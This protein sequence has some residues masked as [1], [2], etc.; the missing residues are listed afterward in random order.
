ME[1]SRKKVSLVP[2]N[3]KVVPE[4]DMKAV[5]SLPEASM[6]RAIMGTPNAFG[7]G[8]EAVDEVSKDMKDYRAPKR[9]R[10]P[11]FVATKPT[12]DLGVSI[13]NLADIDAVNQTFFCKFD[14]VLR[15]QDQT[16]T[17][18]DDTST[19]WLPNVSFRNSSDVQQTFSHETAALSI[20]LEPETESSWLLR[21][22][23]S[24]QFSEPMELFDF[25]FDCQDLTLYL[26]FARYED[27]ML[28]RQLPVDFK[29]HSVDV[30]PSVM[31]N[32]YTVGMP[33][34]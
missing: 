29:N 9:T 32:E 28:L 15:W 23:V 34:Y 10:P 12:C 1:G 2:L 17:T 25:P 8:E 5:V 22:H 4:E 30:L 11:G 19:D 16:R 20:M 7:D 26:R 18:T 31:M 27:K 3:K 14:L 21:S 6:L 33:R 24:G 13:V